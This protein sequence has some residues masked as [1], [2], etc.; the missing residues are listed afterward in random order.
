MGLFKPARAEAEHKHD[1]EVI[2][3]LDV[4][5]S[6]KVNFILNGKVHSLLPI[7]VEIFMKFFAQTIEYRNLKNV[8]AYTE[9]KAFLNVLKTVCKSISLKDVKKMTVMQKSILV[10]GITRKLVGNKGFFEESKD[11][12][13]K[14]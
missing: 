10:E 11:P 6:T 8:D 5:A 2:C 9:N 7:T 14:V 13:K 4:I 12:K 3:D 1:E